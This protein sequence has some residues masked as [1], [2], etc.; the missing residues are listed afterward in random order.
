MELKF[1]FRFRISKLCE[2]CSEVRHAITR[3]T[4][5]RVKRHRRLRPSRDPCGLLSVAPLAAFV[6]QPQR[7]VE[8][9][10]LGRQAAGLEARPR[11]RAGRLTADFPK[12]FPP[13]L[14]L[15]ARCPTSW[16]AVSRRR[17]SILGVLIAAPPRRRFPS[18]GRSTHIRLFR[19][20]RQSSGEPPSA[21]SKCP[22]LFQQHG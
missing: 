15:A 4:D 20:V 21:A 13:T 2:P 7:E 5:M 10:V 19:E 18:P 1:R 3:T 11:S 12:R 22:T 16:R 17:E 14:A 9:R 8:R 6:R